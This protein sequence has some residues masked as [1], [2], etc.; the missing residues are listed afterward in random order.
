VENMLNKE[1]SSNTKIYV[2]ELKQKL[3]DFFGHDREMLNDWM[4]TPLPILEGACPS[5]LVESDEGRARI[6]KMLGN[7]KFGETA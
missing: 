2:A 6:N 5:S 7:M 3:L 1:Q 4:N